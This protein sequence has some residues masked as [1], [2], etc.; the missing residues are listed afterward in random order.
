MKA[1]LGKVSVVQ[2]MQHAYSDFFSLFFSFSFILFL[3][4][5]LSLTTTKGKKK[6]K[7]KKTHAT[8]SL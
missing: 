7:I 5:S 1:G 4:L 3:S 6:I 8:I 2:W